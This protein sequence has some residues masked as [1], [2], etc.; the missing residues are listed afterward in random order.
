VATWRTALQPARTGNVPLSK[1]SLTTSTSTR[2]RRVPRLIPLVNTVEDP[3]SNDRPSHRTHDE[4]PPEKPMRSGVTTHEHS[5]HQSEYSRN[6][7]Y[8][9]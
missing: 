4:Q 7:S 6:C 9:W 5:G 3:R 2:K 1:S 8:L